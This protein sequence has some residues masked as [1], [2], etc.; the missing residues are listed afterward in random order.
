[1]VTTSEGFLF[2]AS[3]PWTEERIA[4]FRAASPEIEAVT[5]IPSVNH[6]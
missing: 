1:V 6:Q 4:A 2:A 5:P 3:E